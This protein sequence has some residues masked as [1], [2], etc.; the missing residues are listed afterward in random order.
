MTQCNCTLLENNISLLKTSDVQEV[1][2]LNTILRAARDLDM[3]EIDNHLKDSF[4]PLSA[5]IEALK[6]DR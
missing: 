1:L 6:L 4:D 5:I 3:D 2:K